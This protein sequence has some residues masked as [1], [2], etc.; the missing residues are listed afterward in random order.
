MIRY[1][2]ASTVERYI[3]QDQKLI[4]LTTEAPPANFF[5]NFFEVSFKEIVTGN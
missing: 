2:E 1:Q 3:N 4:T 5:P